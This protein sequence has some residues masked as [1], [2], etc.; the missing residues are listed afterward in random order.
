MNSFE[1][2]RHLASSIRGGP[3]GSPGKPKSIA[4]EDEPA[5]P[6]FLDQ[7]ERF[8]APDRPKSSA[9]PES[10]ALDTLTDRELEVLTLAAQGRDNEEMAQSLRLSVRTVER[11]LQ[12]IYAKLDIQGKSARAAA[13]ARLLTTG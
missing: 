12:N 5:W 13:V 7:V 9:G 8:L 2:G 6:V 4:Y 11:H 10:A 3:S 1:H